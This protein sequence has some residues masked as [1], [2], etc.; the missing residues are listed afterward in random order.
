MSL[1]T[2]SAKTNRLYRNMADLFIKRQNASFI[3]V[4][5]NDEGIIKDLYEF[6][7]YE[8]PNFTKN[9]WSKWD[10]VVRMYNKGN[11]KLPYGLLQVVLKF[12]EDRK[13]T[14]DLDPK[15][16]EDI[17]N[18][19]REQIASWVKEIKLHSGG[20]E[21]EPYEYQME[22]LYLA[23]RYNRMTLLA[24]T[25]AGKSLVA[26]LL[27]RYYEMLN[28]QDGLKTLLV[29]PSINLVSQMYSDFKDYSVLNG[30]DASIN[31]HTISEGAR[32]NSINP[33]YISTWQSI[34]DEDPDYFH[35]FGRVIV[36]ECFHPD[37]PIKTPEGYKK[38]KDFKV[39]DRVVNFD[40][41]CGV[42]KED[43]VVEVYKNLTISSNE[44]F[45]EITFDNEVII[46]VTGNHKFL[47]RNRG[48][49]RADELTDMDDIE[50]YE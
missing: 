46:K 43:I 41:N 13:Y 15:F 12:A 2:G 21:I 9:K 27:C 34:K 42:Y 10:G 18:I 23:V 33:I 4:L 26:Y 39:G 14:Y 31:C 8:E 24:A 25:S 47:T 50:N 28:N 30:W 17:T 32:K 40:E 19:T 3:Q 20:V 45:F 48:W 35:Q 11:G 7:R 16:K 6:F 29:V 5:S 36:D 22:A 49:V 44:K 37:T 1:D 38:I